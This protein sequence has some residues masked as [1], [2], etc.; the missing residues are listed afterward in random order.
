[1]PPTKAPLGAT[2]LNFEDPAH[3][4]FERLRK[5]FPNVPKAKL[6]DIFNMHEGELD[7][8]ASVLMEQGIEMTGSLDEEDEQIVVNEMDDISPLSDDK[9]EDFFDDCSK[10]TGST[11]NTKLLIG[12]T[13]EED[14]EMFTVSPFADTAIENGYGFNGASGGPTDY[15]NETFELILP[16]DFAR[17]LLNAYGHPDDE[18]RSLSLDELTVKVPVDAAFEIYKSLYL[19]LHKTEMELARQNSS[20]ESERSNSPDSYT[21][22]VCGGG[23]QALSLD[24]ELNAIAIS[25]SQMDLETRSGNP[26]LAVIQD[27]EAK[28]CEKTQ[29]AYRC[30]AAP[31]RTMAQ[32]INLISVCSSRSIFSWILLLSMKFIFSAFSMWIK[33]ERG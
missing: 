23:M 16:A 21:S 27:I 11:G 32:N 30:F 2:C 20:D 10:S 6:E 18:Q 22:D 17:V 5:L 9:C 15:D 28:L 3:Q 19:N 4:K 33:Q 14:D 25:I 26:N 7:D 29:E 1:M 24:D 8:C 31:N 12:N 13:E